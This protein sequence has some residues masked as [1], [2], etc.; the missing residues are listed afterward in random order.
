MKRIIWSNYY[1]DMFTQD[2]MEYAKDFLLEE[3]EE[4]TEED[5]ENHIYAQNDLDFEVVSE[6]I[7]YQFN[8]KGK[9]LA[10]GKVGRW[11][12]TYDGGR[13]INTFRD[14]LDLFRDCDYIKF[15]DENGHFYV[16]GSHHD[17]SISVEVK[18]LT[19]KGED[20]ADRHEYDMSDRNLHK[21]L[22]NSSNYSRLFRY[23]W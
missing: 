15:E 18:E 11:D 22:W 2:A 10:V 7:K 17:G 12:G 13:I 5:I 6:Y 16:T 20:Y 3:N 9:L 14:L 21:K 1:N 8:N 4:V 23:D 19:Q